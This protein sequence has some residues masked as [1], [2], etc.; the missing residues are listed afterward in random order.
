M[1]KPYVSSANY[2]LPDDDVVAFSLTDNETGQTV[3]KHYDKAALL[4]LIAK[5]ITI[6]FQA[7]GREHDRSDAN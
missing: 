4:G 7:W 1:G 3:V 5:L 6:W 2:H